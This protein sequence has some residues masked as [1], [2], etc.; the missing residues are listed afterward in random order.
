MH[1]LHIPVSL[2]LCITPQVWPKA[3]THRHRNIHMQS[4]MLRTRKNPWER[5]GGQWADHV[6]NRCKDS[7]LQ[8]SFW[9]SKT[10]KLTKLNV[11]SAPHLQSCRGLQHTSW[12]AVTLRNM[13]TATGFILSEFNL[14]KIVVSDSYASYESQEILCT[15]GDKSITYRFLFGGVIFGNYDRL[16]SMKFLGELKCMYVRIGAVLP[17]KPWIFRLQLQFFSGRCVGISCCSVT[18]FFT[19]FIFSEYNM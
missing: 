17:W 3:H 1:R 5:R 16:Y 11:C 18:L 10:L 19:G 12:L 6:Y 4:S 14:L 2:P 9:M 8:G 13:T 7:E 15:I